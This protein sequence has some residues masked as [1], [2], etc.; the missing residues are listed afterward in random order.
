MLKYFI[1]VLIFSGIIFSQSI[2]TSKLS[3]GSKKE[4]ITAY[5]KS[6]IYFISVND[7]SEKFSLKS[8]YNTVNQKIELKFSNY[9]LKITAKN[10]FIILIN[11]LNNESKV[12][13]LPVSTFILDKQLF[14]PFEYSK[15]LF[16]KCFGNDL[17]FEAQ[18]EN[19]AIQTNQQQLKNN[20]EENKLDL[21]KINFTIDEKANGTLLS[22]T[23]PNKIY[24]IN[25]SISKD[26]INLKLTDVNFETE[27]FN[28]SFSKGLIKELIAKNIKNNFEIQIALRKNYAAYEVIQ[29]DENHV[30]VTIH[31]K[32]FEK[33]N[34]ID[35]KKNK[36]NFDVIV[37][38]A[39]HGGKDFGAVGINHT[40]EKEINLSVALKL[41]KLITENIKDL[42]VVYTR[43]N[44]S[45][46]EL[47]K[48]GKIANEHNGKL[49]ISIHCNSVPKKIESP[50][51]YEFYLLRPGRTED[52]IAIAERENSV[53]EYEAEPNRYQ[54]LTDEN[55]ILVSMA[56]SSYMKYS[57][58]FSELLDKNFNQKV[59]IASKGIK[60]AGFYV[61]VGAS[62][63]S[64]LIECG[65]V[66]NK[67]D[68]DYLK[69]KTG[70]AEI[71]EAIFNSIKNF[72]S[73]YDSI[74]EAE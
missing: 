62:M 59:S 21:N 64:V 66:T 1:C 9:S 15:D 46:V 5:K 40:I 61:L 74:I 24:S 55:F 33:K 7:L 67:K 54:K 71:A 27:N 17:I 38:D 13:Q 37:I 23:S 56:H 16:A 4:Q 20:D 49:F 14:V 25:H 30:L 11:K 6:G 69:S 45:F 8:F 72:K 41:G 50:N 44:D 3:I 36:W 58:K 63:P 48:R 53:I 12:L 19:A 42:K 68:S 39:G 2:V 34:A 70:Q 10:P 35:S 31:N 51:G 47:Y 65:Y 52:A 43:S 28:Q 32:K 18:E 29:N 26:I 57:E 60:Q 73:Y 22:L